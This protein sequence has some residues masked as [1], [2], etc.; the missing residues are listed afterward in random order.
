MSSET[1]LKNTI[2]K[3]HRADQ[4]LT[5]PLLQE[6]IANMRKDLMKEF[7]DTGLNGDAERLDIWQRSQILNGLLEQF[8]KS[9]KEGKAAQSLLERMKTKLR[10]VI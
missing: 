2:Q 6:F 8:K 10:N 1:E 4:L 3:A 7:E 5:D 9:N